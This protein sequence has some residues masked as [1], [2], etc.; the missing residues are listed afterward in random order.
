M[1]SGK[2]KTMEDF[3]IRLTG[4]LSSQYE[5]TYRAYVWGRSKRLW[6]MTASSAE[7]KDSRSWWKVS[8]STTR[9]LAELAPAFD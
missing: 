7:Q 1:R 2:N 3:A 4:P 5:L 9:E 8:G 6:L